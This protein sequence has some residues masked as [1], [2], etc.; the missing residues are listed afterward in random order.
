MVNKK[1]CVILLTSLIITSLFGC[2]SGG[3]TAN[4][5][6][7]TSSSGAQL[8]SIALTPT[9]PTIAVDTD[10]QFTATG[11]YSDN[12]TKDLTSTVTWTSSAMDALNVASDADVAQFTGFSASTAD[13][14]STL[15][16]A[17]RTKATRSGRA[18]ITAKW[19][20]ISG[21]TIV[22]VTSATLVSIDI[23]PTEPSIVKGTNQQFVAT[24]TFS[25]NTTQDL[26][27]TVT[28]GSSDAAVAA[29]SN[30]AGSNGLTTSAAAGSTTITATSG[31]ISGSTSLTVTSAVLVS[32]AV[33]PTNPSIAPGTTQQFTATGTYSDNTT[34]DLTTTVMWNSSTAAVAAIS[35]SAGSNGLANSVATGSTTITATSG[36]ISGI[37]T[38]TVTPATLVSITLT[39]TNPSIALGTS[40][41]FTATGTYS[42]N[43]T[44]NL[45]TS[46]TW[47]S[48]STT[49]AAISNAAGSNGKATSVAAGSTTITA[50]SGGISGSTALT[51]TSA[52]LVS[53]SVTPTNPSIV[54]GTFKQF[55]ATGTYSDNSTQN[56][57]TSATWK[58]S[59]TT[60]AAISNAAGSNGKATSVAAGSTTITATSG[61]ISGSTT[62]TVTSATLVSIAVTPTNQSISLGATQQFTAT[63]T[64]SNS[65]T[66]N[67]TTAVTWKSSTAAI[68]SISNAAGSNGLA[69]SVA[70]GSTTITATSGSVSGT[71][72]LAV[73]G[74][75]VVSLAW[76]APTTNTDGSSLNPATDLSLYKIYYGSASLTYA[77]VVNVTNPGTT[78]ISKTLN[79]SP[80]TYYFSVTTVDSSGQESSYS[81][82]VMK[83]I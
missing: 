57:T 79:L 32:I 1:A 74:S 72:T 43:S 11:T 54:L 39:P 49:V 12:T 25:D 38:L 18:K 47:K 14:S 63:G 42:D 31:S 50:T 16:S 51:V 33:N 27:A 36:S 4:L 83:T 61:S 81:N 58:S 8:E 30:A 67:L 65:S 53:I 13:N 41:Q 80:G 64:Y 69:T 77:T 68:A 44:Q 29:I 6:T 3:G 78:T 46:V 20:S 24:G 71:A 62:L 22:T 34:Q 19:G 40:K 45:T 76:D 66:Q 28:W 7:S 17:G 21:S 59:S 48:S 26:T 70:A 15:L 73:T 2:G 82:E 35:S 37:S 9:N 75:G 56:L 5:D 10:I 23:T 60:V 55:T 52:T